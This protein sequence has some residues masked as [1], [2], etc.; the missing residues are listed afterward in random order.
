MNRMDYPEFKKYATEWENRRKY[1]KLIT[2]IEKFVNKENEVVFYPKN[3][4]LEDYYLELYFFGRN[5]IVILNER[6]DDVLVKVLRCDQIQSVEL[7]YVDMD[8]PVNLCIEFNNDETIE[9]NDKTDTD[10]SWSGQFT[11]KIEEIFKLLN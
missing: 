6:E 4:F 3:L 9:L 11:T 10:T 2:S 8:E 7:T 5:K 1:Q